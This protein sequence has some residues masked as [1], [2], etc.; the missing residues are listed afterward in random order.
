M[1]TYNLKG[2]RGF[3]GKFPFDN[4]IILK[5]L[6]SNIIVIVNTMLI[7]FQKRIV[8]QCFAIAGDCLPVRNEREMSSMSQEKAV[9]IVNLINCIVLTS[10]SSTR[11]KTSCGICRG[12]DGR[13]VFNTIAIF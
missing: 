9:Q 1:N 5:D 12:R 6:F 3:D 7:V 4:I 8:K 2:T 10:L 13:S 11:C